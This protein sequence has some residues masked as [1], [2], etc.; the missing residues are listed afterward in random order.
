MYYD[1]GV[2]EALC[3]GWVDSKP[4][5]RDEENYYLFMAQRKPGSNWSKLNRQ[6]AGNLMAGGRWLERVW[7]WRRSQSNPA[8]GRPWNMCKTPWCRQTWPKRY[9]PIRPQRGN[10]DGFPP[11]SKR[12]I[13][14][15]ILNAKKPETRQKRKGNTVALAAKNIKANHCRQ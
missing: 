14:E 6:R 9:W 15:W 5:K 1:E 10:F 2:E 13:L 7:P 4:N 3:Y 11:S 8:P 12:V